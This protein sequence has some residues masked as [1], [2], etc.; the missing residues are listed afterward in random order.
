MLAVASWAAPS[1][2]KNLTVYGFGQ[3]GCGVL[4]E[5]R[6][7]PDW[8]L[9]FTSWLAGFSSGLNTERHIANKSIMSEEL[10][11]DQMHGF[12]YAYCLYAYCLRQPA[13]PIWSAAVDYY[14]AAAK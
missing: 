3:T 7:D 13:D 14:S 1:N 8:K 9:R 12:I 6:T 10:D 5:K 11:L 2:A 4:I